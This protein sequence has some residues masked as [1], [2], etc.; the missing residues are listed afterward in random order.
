MRLL[1]ASLSGVADAAW[2][3]AVASHVDCALLGGLALDGPT[4]E[5]ARAMVA[6]DREEFLPDDPVAWAEREF[7]G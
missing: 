1:A 3:R 4:R 2:G 6:R 7:A 5:A